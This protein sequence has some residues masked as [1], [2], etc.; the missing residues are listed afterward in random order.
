MTNSIR[1]VQV[2]TYCCV[3]YYFELVDRQYHAQCNN[4]Q[5]LDTIFPYHSIEYV[6]GGED[7]GSMGSDGQWTGMIGKVIRKV[8]Q[9]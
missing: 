6:D 9:S 2:I 3:L 8:S 1:M 7:Y 5:T 4:D